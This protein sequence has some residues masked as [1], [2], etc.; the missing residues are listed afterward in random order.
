VSTLQSVPFT[1]CLAIALALGTRAQ[2][3]SRTDAQ[4]DDLAG[5]VKSVS[6]KVARGNVRW[7]QPG[8]PTL[9][10]PI[11]CMDCEYDRDGNRIKSGQVVDGKFLGEVVQLTNDETGRLTT[12]L[13]FNDSNGQLNRQEALGPFGKTEEID[14]IDGRP[15]WKQQYSYDPYGHM[16]EWLS[17]DENRK[18]IGRVHIAQDPGG[19][20]RERS[21]WNEDGRLSNQQTFDPSTNVEQFT[22]FDDLGLVKLTWTVVNGKLASFWELPGS[23]SQFGDGFV[24]HGSDGDPE[25]YT[26]HSD[27]TC[28]VSRI[29]YDYLSPKKRNPLSAEWRDAEGNLKYAVYYDYQ[30]DSFANWNRRQVWVWSPD[31]GQRTAYEVDTREITYWQK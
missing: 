31:T 11:L 16:V 27:G 15:H 2:E 9:L 3:L 7:E 26:C 23:P 19:T 28:D 6:T 30:I 4:N 5:P 13:Y 17:F 18:L 22:T 21:V 10:F 12:R 20:L 8:G 25:D 24:E 14:Y 29:H 1:F